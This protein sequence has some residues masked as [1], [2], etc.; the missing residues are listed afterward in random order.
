MSDSI[1]RCADPECDWES[2]EHVP[3]ACRSC[4][5]C[6][7]TLPPWPEDEDAAVLPPIERAAVVSLGPDDVLFLEITGPVDAAVDLGH[8]VKAEVQEKLDDTFGRK[9]KFILTRHLRPVVVKA[10][11]VEDG[12]TEPRVDRDA[13]FK[14]YFELK[15]V[16]RWR[17]MPND[18]LDRFGVGLG[19]GA[20]KD[21][22]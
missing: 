8:I 15:H 14:L 6:G 19:L 12:E 10:E 3:P 22:E 16:L 11:A 17:D 7:R 21:P 20:K 18:W 13:L 5:R 1:L 4:P 9:V 2:L